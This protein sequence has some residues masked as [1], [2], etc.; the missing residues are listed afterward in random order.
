MT[1][2]NRKDELSEHCEVLSRNQIED[3]PKTLI[4]QIGRAKNMI[5]FARTRLELLRQHNRFD[6]D[7]SDQGMLIL[8]E[9][10]MNGTFVPQIPWK[11]KYVRYLMEHHWLGMMLTND[12]CSASEVIGFA[13]KRVRCS[14]IIEG[15]E[16]EHQIRSKARPTQRWNE[17]HEEFVSLKE[18]ASAVW[19]DDLKDQLRVAVA[20]ELHWYNTLHKHGH[21]NLFHF[22]H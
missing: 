1:C 16:K 4:R 17:G 12:E 5:Y 22:A 7:V 19:I 14:K 21:S 2:E 9:H 8:Y 15:I 3:L 11:S 20:D 10:L 6:V 18:Q 13:E